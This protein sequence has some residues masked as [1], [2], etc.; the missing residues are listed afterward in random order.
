MVCELCPNKNASSQKQDICIFQSSIFSLIVLQGA[1]PRSG[2]MGRNQLADHVTHKVP[3]AP[4]L[5]ELIM[6]NED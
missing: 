5:K 3:L 4:S 2:T 1:R 6:K